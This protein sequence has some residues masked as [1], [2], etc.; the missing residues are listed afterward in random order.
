MEDI[1]GAL[2]TGLR[3][4]FV[5]SQF[6][7]LKDL[8]ESKLKPDCIIESLQRFPKDIDQLMK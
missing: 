5:P 6:N 8:E 1:K 4:V 7:S 3:A 2:D